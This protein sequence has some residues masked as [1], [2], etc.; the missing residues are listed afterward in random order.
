MK[1]LTL[2]TPPAAEPVTLAEAKAHL[3]VEIADDDA[4]IADLVAAARQAAE[5]H[6]RRA[7]IT[8]TW[9]LTLDRFPGKPLP[10]WD[11]VREGADVPEP[12]NAI[13]LPRPP[14]QSVTSVTAY[15]DADAAT[16]MAAT[17]YFV[18]SDHE[19]GRVVLRSGKTWPVVLRVA[20]G[21]EIEYVAG[22]GAATDVPEAIRQGLLLLVGHFYENREAVAAAGAVSE[23][24]LGVA[25]LWRPYRVPGL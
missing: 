14:L 15:D 23:L 3:R 21:V 5:S 25:A 17:D 4:L 7:L 12:A 13:E 18:D 11:G 1:G 22:Y 24:P 9:R 8:Q 16:V 2:V 10:W 6:T 20:A 19:P